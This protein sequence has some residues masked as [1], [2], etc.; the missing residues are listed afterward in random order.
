MTSFA[1]RSPERILTTSELVCSTAMGYP[2]PPLAV[3]REIV[4]EIEGYQRVIDG[5]RAVVENYRPH[6]AIDP[7]WPTVALGELLSFVSSGATPKGGKAS[8]PDQ[9]ILFIRSQNILVG[10]HDFSDAVFIS[11]ETHDSMSRSK[12]AKGD[13]FLN[14][15]G[16]SIGRSARMDLAIEANVNQHVAILRATECLDGLFLSV[17]L[18]SEEGQ[19][20][21]AALQAGASRQAL[22][23]SQIRQ[24]SIPLPPLATQ[25]AIVAEIEAEQALVAANRELIERFE[26][27]IQST[28]T[29]VWGETP[30]NVLA[31]LVPSTGLGGP[32]RP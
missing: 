3:Q 22:N 24:L 19:D 29:R 13:V 32:L 25:Q 6:I 21:I 2:L 28:L 12:V 18:N 1:N 31:R 14:I 10:T 15:T 20:Q 5:A 11:K 17:F 4:A 30:P 7:E 23:Y 16:A 9:G 27:K 8:Y 26:K